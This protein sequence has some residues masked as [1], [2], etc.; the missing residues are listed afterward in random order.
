MLFD[1]EATSFSQSEITSLTAE[2]SKSFS[3]FTQDKISEFEISN[4]DPHVCQLF[5]TH[6]VT[7]VTQAMTSALNKTPE[8]LLHQAI[9]T[10]HLVLQ[11]SECQWC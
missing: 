1:H 8:Q 10:L 4:S 3:S 9:C 6:T 7:T 5:D 2:V 11:N